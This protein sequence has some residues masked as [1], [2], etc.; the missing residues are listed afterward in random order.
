MPGLWICTIILHVRQAFE[1]ASGSKQ[2][3]VLHM[4][5]LYK[6]GLRRVRNMSDYG[7]IH[8]NYAR[9]YL[10]LP[11]YPSTVLK[12]TEYSW[13]SLNMSENAWINCSDYVKVL[14]MPRYSY[15]NIIIIVT[16]VILL[17]FLSAS[18]VHPGAL[19]PFP[20]F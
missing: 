11:Y 20:L 3:R 17:E 5:R 9:I 2:A 4:A 8:L 12:I 13:I 19:I 7:S 1:D 14:H 16:N 6:Q 15:N 10:N 18:F